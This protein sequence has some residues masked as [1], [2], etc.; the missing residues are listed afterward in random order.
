[1]KLNTNSNTYII[2]YSAIL[3]VIVAFLLAFVYKALKPMQDANVELDMKKQ[4]LYSLNIRD[5]DGA[6]AEAKY[7]ELVNDTMD[8]M[9]QKILMAEVNEEPIMIFE[10][11][12]MGLW[13]GISGY[14]ATC[15]DVE[16]MNLVV[17]GAY[18]N[19]ESET[20]GLGAEI[21]DSQ[22]WQEK[23]IG[24]KII[25]EVEGKDK[26]VLSIVK[27]VEDPETQVDC[28]TGATL[29]SNG[30]DEMIKRTFGIWTGEYDLDMDEKEL[31]KQLIK[32]FMGNDSIS[33]AE[34]ERMIKVKKVKEE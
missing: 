21:K 25:A 6:A 26:V 20:A 28:V 33:D 3:V 10:M 34:L 8:F 19:H 23:F 30:V 24:K 27:K 1:M 32:C 7:A 17:Y 4:V 16:T 31:E 12:G 9:G 11:K 29:T 5:L 22:E 14:M 13:G 15:F 18:F 2:I